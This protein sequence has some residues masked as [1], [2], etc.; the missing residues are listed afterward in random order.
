MFPSTPSFIFRGTRRCHI[1]TNAAGSVHFLL[2]LSSAYSAKR[3]L[4]ENCARRLLSRAFLASPRPG[5]VTQPPPAPTEFFGPRLRACPTFA[6][7]A[8]ARM[9]RLG[10][11][12]WG[13]GFEVGRA[14][15]AGCSRAPLHACPRSSPPSA[16]AGFAQRSERTRDAQNDRCCVR[17]LPRPSKSAYVEVTRRRR[18]TWCREKRLALAP[19]SFTSLPLTC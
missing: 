1:E 5:D 19:G 2:I 11:G 6:A 17:I 13:P 3:Y 14:C 8:V 15:V 12:E 4:V 18:T 9:R 10:V 7:S 16:R